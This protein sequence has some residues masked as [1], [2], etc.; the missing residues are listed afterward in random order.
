[1]LKLFGSRNAIAKILTIVFMIIYTI[2][3]VDACFIRKTGDGS[4]FFSYVSF[5]ASFI[6]FVPIVILAE[7]LGFDIPNGVIQDVIIYIAGILQYGLLGYCIGLAT[8]D[9]IKIF[10][11]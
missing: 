10:C 8:N 1:M 3:F 11:K 9:I 4:L 7:V 5:P 6:L 2:L